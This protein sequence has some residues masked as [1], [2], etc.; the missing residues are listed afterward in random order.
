MATDVLSN[1]HTDIHTFKGE[2][3]NVFSEN[4]FLVERLYY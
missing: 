1:G 4:R 3:K 2:L